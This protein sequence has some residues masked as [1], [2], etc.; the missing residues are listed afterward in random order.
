MSR[1]V[2]YLRLLPQ[3]GSDPPPALPGLLSCPR[4][5]QA[6]CHV[7]QDT[8]LE[9]EWLHCRRC[10]LA[11]DM[12]EVAA[13][14]WNLELPEAVA[15]MTAEQ[16]WT[17]PPLPEVVAWYL[18]RVAGTRREISRFWATCRERLWS[19]PERN[20]RDLSHA[21]GL[22][23]AGTGQ[24]SLLLLA[25][26]CPIPQF[27]EWVKQHGQHG[28]QVG[29]TSHVGQPGTI[30]ATAG[31]V[32]LLPFSDLPGR[33]CGWLC[34][35]RSGQRAQGDVVYRRL[36]ATRAG[37]LEAGVGFLHAALNN[38]MYWQGQVL[39]T[40]DVA[41]ARLQFQHLQVNNT[42]LPLVLTHCDKYRTQRWPWLNVEQRLVCW[43][44]DPERLT[45]VATAWPIDAQTT[46]WQATNELPSQ[47]STGREILESAVPWSQRL[48][49]HLLRTSVSVTAAI[50]AC[51]LPTEVL[52]RAAASWS[53]AAQARLAQVRLVERAA[54]VANRLVVETDLGWQYTSGQ[55]FA[56]AVLRID[57]VW[58]TGQDRSHYSGRVLYKGSTLE[59]FEP[60]QLLDREGL[61]WVRDRVRDQTG[62]LIQ[63]DTGRADRAVD[64]ARRFHEPEKRRV[65]LH[66]GWVAASQ[67]FAWHGYGIH[68]GQVVADPQCLSPRT[69][70]PTDLAPWSPRELQQ[71]SQP[72]PEAG[73]FWL[74]LAAAAQN[75]TAP[76][77]REPPIGILL[78]GDN[79]DGAVECLQQFGCPTGRAPVPGWLTISETG[80][81]KAG[82]V[83]R[84][85]ELD[86]WVA[87]LNGDVAWLACP[88]YW[89]IYSPQFH[90]LARSLPRY[91]RWLTGQ[92]QKLLLPPGQQLPHALDRTLCNLQ[93]WFQDEGGDPEVVLARR[94]QLRVPDASNEA[95]LRLLQHLLMLGELP[96]AYEG[97]DDGPESGSIW[98]ESRPTIWF[99]QPLLGRALHRLTTEPPPLGMLITAMS[100]LPGWRGETMCHGL[101]GW[102]LDADWWVKQVQALTAG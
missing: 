97:R 57:C 41:G 48:Q 9:G 7:Y 56:D 70:L 1:C 95:P 14:V 60:A 94:E 3:L 102:E 32:L 10:G 59:F 22:P 99:S 86:G 28:S 51:E 61:R 5:R 74:L 88:Y 96:G 73:M 12:I 35:S 82:Y 62:D 37:G 13:R 16:L 45:D 101:P 20:L 53:P 55:P 85:S 80:R 98:R 84:G 47:V 29:D 18:E 72:D 23:A 69:P 42:P 11:G 91:L 46:T 75:L 89:P 6:D 71:L 83:G 49:L 33:I 79:V 44:P 43:S 2:S 30:K 100:R 50:K 17:V 67:A 25:G 21:L 68:N 87:M 64:V 34:L 15:R 26:E 66:P 76:L 4:C 78:S 63:I 24:E 54:A 93:R 65:Q 58:Y 36:W 38:T 92:K 52:A 77:M 8:I 81:P 19:R 40:D 27:Q 31:N 90:P 39:A